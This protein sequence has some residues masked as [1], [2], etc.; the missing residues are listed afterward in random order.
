MK[1]R[2]SFVKPA[3]NFFKRSSKLDTVSQVRPSKS[4]SVASWTHEIF[5][6]F[7]FEKESTFLFSSSRVLG[8]AAQHCGEQIWYTNWIIHWVFLGWHFYLYLGSMLR[9]YSHRRCCFCALK[10]KPVQTRICCES[11]E[12]SEQSLP[13]LCAKVSRCALLRKMT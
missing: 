10:N 3:Q 5:P 6:F 13:A 8:D 4:N 11:T 2:T 1:S 9:N 12:V 7:Y